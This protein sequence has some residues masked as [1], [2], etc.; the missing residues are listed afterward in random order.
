MVENE[1]MQRA[2]IIANKEISAAFL[3]AGV[4]S[5]TFTFKYMI[6][7]CQQFGKPKRGCEVIVAEERVMNHRGHGVNEESALVYSHCI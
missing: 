1:E 7:S 3:K 2:K 4:K 6:L 5:A